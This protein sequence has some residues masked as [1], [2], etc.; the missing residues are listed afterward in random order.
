MPV[1][2]PWRAGAVR[3]VTGGQ[4]SCWASTAEWFSLQTACPLDTGIP[5]LRTPNQ[6][7]NRK[8]CFWSD[9]DNERWR[10]EGQNP[11]QERDQEF[12]GQLGTATSLPTQ[13][14]GFQ[15]PSNPGTSG[16]GGSCSCVSLLCCVSLFRLLEERAISG[17][18]LNKES[19]IR[20]SPQIYIFKN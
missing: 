2:A 10:K 8:R 18:G 1:P 4:Q 16:G 13:C 6:H 9:V 11:H 7:S 5:P 14:C 20:H 15:A 19:W 3:L 17:L 12:R